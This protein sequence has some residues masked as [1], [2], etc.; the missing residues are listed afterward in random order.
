MLFRSPVRGFHV[1]QQAAKGLNKTLKGLEQTCKGLVCTL[2]NAAKNRDDLPQAPPAMRPSLAGW[3]GPFTGCRRIAEACGSLGA[4][5]RAASCGAASMQALEWSGKGMAS[6]AAKFPRLAREVQRAGVRNNYGHP[7]PCAP[8]ASPTPRAPGGRATRSSCA[9]GRDAFAR[10][11]RPCPV[12]PRFPCPTIAPRAVRQ[13]PVPSAKAGRTGRNPRPW[14]EQ[15]GDWPQIHPAFRRPQVGQR[16]IALRGHSLPTPPS[17][18][19]SLPA[20][21]LRRL[22]ERRDL[23]WKLTLQIYTDANP[24]SFSEVQKNPPRRVVRCPPR[25]LPLRHAWWIVIHGARILRE[26][27]RSLRKRRTG[28]FDRRAPLTHMNI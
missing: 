10:C 1:F 14:R 19:I 4:C 18:R 2:S 7:A 3:R 8:P 27:K 25:Q 13:C 16:A 17:A 23:R 5:G 20:C 12:S 28:F 26:R 22:W 21:T 9:S 11:P 6:D 15:G 24:G